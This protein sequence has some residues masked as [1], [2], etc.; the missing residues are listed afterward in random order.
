M[1]WM[2]KLPLLLTFLLLYKAV[3]QEDRVITTAVPFLTIAADARAAGM[4]DMGVATSV[5]AFSQQWNPAKFAF[6]EQKMGIG[7]SYT[8]YLE[9]IITDIS[10]LVSNFYNKINDQSSFAF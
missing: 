2:K 3:A 6:A 8:P 1:N 10:L 9:S 7:V 5:D 4:G